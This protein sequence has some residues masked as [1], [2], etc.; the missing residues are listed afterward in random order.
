[1]EKT[2]FGATELFSLNEFDKN[3]VRDNSKYAK[4]Y[5][6]GRFKAVP[7]LSTNELVRFLNA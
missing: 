5:L 3:L 6:D 4:Y 2:A 7:A 1:M